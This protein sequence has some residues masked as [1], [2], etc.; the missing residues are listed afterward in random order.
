MPEPPEASDDRHVADHHDGDADDVD[1]GEG[2]GV[3]DV[4]GQ[5][6]VEVQVAPGSRELLDVAAQGGVDQGQRGEGHGHQ[7]AA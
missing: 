3:G 1:Q 2:G 6:G 5:A 4:P 7:P